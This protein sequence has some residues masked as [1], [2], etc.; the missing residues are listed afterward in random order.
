MQTQNFQDQI[1]HL[2]RIGSALT[3]ILD[4]D[5]LLDVIVKSARELTNSD[6]GSLYIV[7]GNRLVFIVAQN[8]TLSKKMDKEKVKKLFKPITLPIS[9]ESLAGHVASTG[10]TLNIGDVNSLPRDLRCHFNDAIA[11]HAT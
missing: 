3:S 1:L 10:K 6:A 2:T 4:L 11:N 5:K 8:D 9:S 7:K